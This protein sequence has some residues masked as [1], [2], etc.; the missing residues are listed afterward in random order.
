M[1]TVDVRVLLADTVD[2][3]CFVGQLVTQTCGPG[4]PLGA[5]RLI[6]DELLCTCDDDKC[7]TAITS[8]RVYVRD[9]VDW[10]GSN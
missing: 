6:P 10:D 9:G 3:E 2:E 4:A 5:T 8:A 7:P 1:K